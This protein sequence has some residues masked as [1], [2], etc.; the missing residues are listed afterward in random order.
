MSDEAEPIAGA[1]PAEQVPPGVAHDEVQAEA[2]PL[3][4]PLQ[5]AAPVEGPD[6]ESLQ[7]VAEQLDALGLDVVAGPGAEGG[8]EL[9]TEGCGS[10]AF[11]NGRRYALHRP[12]AHAAQREADDA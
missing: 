9:Q 1:P 8:T 2:L 7:A 6:P 11:L 10:A 4:Q 3:A 5:D 12:S